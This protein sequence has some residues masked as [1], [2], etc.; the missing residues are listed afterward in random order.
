MLF[1]SRSGNP[2]KSTESEVPEGALSAEYKGKTVYIYPAQFEGVKG[3]KCT[4]LPY[5]K[6]FVSAE[7]IRALADENVH[8][9]LAAFV[10]MLD[11]E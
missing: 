1:R 11:G 7:T 9:M 6:S 10:E 5:K 8:A 4:A 2:Q 3:V